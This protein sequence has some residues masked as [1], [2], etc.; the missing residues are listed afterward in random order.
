M[1]KLNHNT[2]NLLLKD[3]TT[4]KNIIFATND[5]KQL[6]DKYTA[7][8]EITIENLYYNNERIIIPRLQKSKHDQ[9]QRT[10][11]KA[12]VFTPSWVCNLQNNLIDQQW[13]KRDKV[14]NVAHQ[15]YWNTIQQIIE[16]P[17]D[18]T[19]SQYVESRRLQITCGEAPYLVSR[20]DT[21][22]GDYID[23]KSRIGLLDR[24]L[25]IINENVDDYIEWFNYTKK[26]YQNTYGFEIQGDNLLIARENLLHTFIDNMVYK[27]DRHPTDNELNQIIDIITWNIFQMD[28]LLFIIPYFD[29]NKEQVYCKIKD[30]KEC[31]VLIYKDLYNNEV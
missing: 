5:Y 27:F 12:E 22:T 13:F 18:K 16:F 9:K 21:D 25:R 31:K 26:A 7:D 2:L 29:D 17:K 8:S 15:K 6:D 4:Q 24:K 19:W 3:R 1:F 10:K 11:K 30:W 23:L 28:G 14:F 20:Y